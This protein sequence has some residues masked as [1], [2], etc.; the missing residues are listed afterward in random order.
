MSFLKASGGK[1]PTN[2]DP[3]CIPGI[4]LLL[5]SWPIIS[6]ALLGCW[7]SNRGFTPVSFYGIYWESILA[8]Y[9]SQI[10]S[11]TSH[12]PWISP[13]RN[14]SK[15]VKWNHPDASYVQLDRQPH[16]VP[17]LECRMD[18]GVRLL[19]AA[20][21]LLILTLINGAL[22]NPTKQKYRRIYSRVFSK[23]NEIM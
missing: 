7:V 12:F 9:Y 21:L 5:A 17:G 20:E 14:I 22:T 6:A 3:C 15:G 11:V 19:R 13:V 18:C 8:A 10:S 23:L 4:S 16:S 2:L 1:Y